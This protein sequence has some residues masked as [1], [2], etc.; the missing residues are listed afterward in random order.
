MTHTPPVPAGNQSP[1][2]LQEPKH[3]KPSGPP[4]GAKVARTPEPQAVSVPSVIALAAG[5]GLA[6][7]AG[8]LF[9]ALSGGKAK[10]RKG[11]KAR[12][13]KASQAGA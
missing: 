4:E 6:A 13:S 5:V 11:R 1:Y 2:P 12:K 10:K 7:V 3:D 9:Y 8:G